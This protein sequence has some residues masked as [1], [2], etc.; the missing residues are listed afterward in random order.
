MELYPDPLDPTVSLAIAQQVEL[1]F[2]NTALARDSFLL[3]H[4]KRNRF[5]ILSNYP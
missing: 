4:V 3:K 1:V 5:H 2:S